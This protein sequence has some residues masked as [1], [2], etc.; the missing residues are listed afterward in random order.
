MSVFIAWLVANF[1]TVVMPIALATVALG[2]LIAKITPSPKDDQVF[3]AILRFLKLVP[4]PA[5]VE[6]TAGPAPS[7]EEP[8]IMG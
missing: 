7:D 2:A 5:N 1:T 8:P 4:V 6:S 3:A